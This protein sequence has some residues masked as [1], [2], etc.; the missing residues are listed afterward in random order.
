MESYKCLSCFVRSHPH[1]TTCVACQ[2][3]AVNRGQ[4][5]QC[6]TLRQQTV[7]RFWGIASRG[8][9]AESTESFPPCDLVSG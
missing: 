9:V 4:G 7:N 8:R 6:T 2:D 1:G 5:T 3:L